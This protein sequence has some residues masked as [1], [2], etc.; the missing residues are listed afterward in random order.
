MKRIVIA[1]CMALALSGCAGTKLGTFV[2]SVTTGFQNPITKDT[3][4]EFENGMTIAFAGLNA[5]KKSCIAG[6]VP[7]S[8]RQI[9][10][11]LQ[12]YTRKIPT[13][14]KTVRGFV[15]NNDQVNAQTAYATLIDLYNQFKTEAT[16]NGV[17]VQ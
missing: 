12:V 11:N 4:Y 5:Y 2:Q 9:I 14:L 8:C 13:A 7:S 1:F 3:L 10:A 15:K 6:A 17:Q 16:V